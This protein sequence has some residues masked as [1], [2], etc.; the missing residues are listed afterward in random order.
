GHSSSTVL[1]LLE[2]P[3]TGV[4]P[5]LDEAAVA[6]DMSGLDGPE[7]IVARL[8]KTYAAEN[9]YFPK[10]SSKYSKDHFSVRHYAGGIR[11]NCEDFIQSNCDAAI[12]G[13]IP[14]EVKDL[15]HG[16]TRSD[17]FR[18]SDEPASAISV[19]S[20]VQRKAV[21]LAKAITTENSDFIH[22]IKPN[23]K[24]AF[25]M[26]DNRCVADQ[27]RSL[28]LVQVHSLERKGVQ[29]GI[30]YASF[31]D[32]FRPIVAQGIK[33]NRFIRSPRLL[34]QCV[35]SSMGVPSEDLLW[36]N[37]QVFVKRS[38]FLMVLRV[39]GLVL[40]NEA[41]AS[42]DAVAARTNLIISARSWLVRRSFRVA[43]SWLQ[44]CD[45]F[46]GL[47]AN[48]R[49]RKY[50]ISRIRRNGLGLQLKGGRE[51]YQRKR[52]VRNR[53]RVA[54]LMVMACRMFAEEA[55]LIAATKQIQNEAITEADL[56]IKKEQAYLSSLSQYEQ[57]GT[58]PTAAS[59]KAKTEEDELDTPEST[60]ALPSPSSI[61]VS[62]LPQPTTDEN[63]QVT[64]GRS[65]REQAA[66]LKEEMQFKKEV[67][68]LK[69]TAAA[70]T[71]AS[72]IVR[73]KK[74]H[75]YAGFDKWLEVSMG[76]K[77]GL[78]DRLKNAAGRSL[79]EHSDDEDAVGCEECEGAQNAVMWCP[80]CPSSYC[81]LCS[82]FVHNSCRIM[83]THEPIPIEDLEEQDFD[84][85][86][87]SDA[88][89][90]PLRGTEGGTLQRMKLGL[91]SSSKQVTPYRG[92]ASATHT[93]CTI[94]SCDK[95][96]TRG[97][98]L[99]FC[100]THYKL[101]RQ[102]VAP[103]AGSGGEGGGGDR[104]NLINQIAL[105]KKQL[106]ATGETALEFV[107]LD[108]ARNRMQAA[109]GKLMAGDDSAEKDIELWDKTI[110]MHPDYAK[111]QADK[112][113]K[114]ELDNRPRNAQALEVLRGMVPPEIA[115]SSVGKM[116]SE[117]LPRSVAQRI[118]KVKVLQW[119]RWHPDDIKKIH[120]AD[121][122]TK[123]SNQGLDVEEMRALWHIM[124][125]EFDLDGD[126]SKAQWRSNFKQ[127]LMELTGKEEKNQLS[128]NETR[129][130]AWKGC[131]DMVVY[132]T[133]TPLVRMAHHKSTAFDKT[134]QATAVIGNAGEVKN[135]MNQLSSDK[136]KVPPS[137]FEGYL[138]LLGKRVYVTYRG[139]KLRCYRS[140]DDA[141]HETQYLSPV[142]EYMH[143][144][145]S[146]A[147]NVVQIVTMAAGGKV[148]SFEAE[149][150]DKAKAWVDAMMGVAPPPLPARPSSVA[151]NAPPAPLMGGPG[152]GGAGRG[153]LLGAIA[154]RG[155]GGDAG[156]GNLMAAIAGRG[157]GGGGP[158]PGPA[159]GGGRGDLLA[160]IAKRGGGAG[161]NNPASRGDLLAAIA[162]K[163]GGG[164]GQA[165]TEEP[166][167][168]RNDLLA[169]ILARKQPEAVE[170]PSRSPKARPRSISPRR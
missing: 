151:R 92:I 88:P 145:S 26:F 155:R 156:R 66:Q 147:N 6:E 85:E 81:S 134:E 170:K 122:R 22:C 165:E 163:G 124:P 11:Y 41:T 82:S 75:L 164:E 166:A 68:N 13:D 97:V 4:F 149:D 136:S 51:R 58:S 137:K 52:L 50:A 32:I 121:L 36:G 71:V 94:K 9:F 15:L 63:E 40:E 45:M 83:R 110:R 116:V 115:T 62:P 17:M 3:T 87:E 61:Q 84:D 102:V 143:H 12:V 35:L 64:E 5:L 53:W 65:K 86:S 120:I 57:Q 37:S 135:L 8:R 77:V 111:E 127:K 74:V 139:E 130:A 144:S 72:C 167:A 96:A 18:F 23:S 98:A 90:T 42:A 14:R 27:I 43:F 54:Y 79:G 56:D 19:V 168:P 112:E 7:I 69:T 117:G 1:S 21:G 48:S 100:D 129:A 44:A 108:E 153:D 157:R 76:E 20:R 59:I 159:G 25:G 55:A 161:Q 34:A 60:T 146:N 125:D 39:T 138:K 160:A 30:F 131:E 158:G 169:A 107:S 78:M 105:L 80:D 101:F 31:E 91:S 113:R 106:A 114:W 28:G 99:R 93:Q 47:L 46:R 150:E 10:P 73:W 119:A 89:Q 24:L 95:P 154:G 103:N 16:S 118:W 70:M 132:A 148:M 2:Q 140:M 104:V 49:A 67:M 29:G 126:G 128:R 162:K 133:D 38:S 109:V 141:R 152:R 142:A 123:Y 33:G